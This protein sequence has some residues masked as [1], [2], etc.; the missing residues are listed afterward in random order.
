MP[1][2]QLRITED[3]SHNRTKQDLLQLLDS[4]RLKWIKK[5]DSAE[6]TCG[7]EQLNKFGEACPPHFHL[8]VYFDSPDVKDPLRSAKEFLK[9]KSVEI[10]FRL[11]G[12]KVWSCTLVEEPKDY[13]RWIRYPLKETPCLPFC[14]LPGHDLSHLHVLAKEERKRGVEINILKREKAIDKQSFKDKLFKYLDDHLIGESV[15][16]LMENIVYDKTLPDHQTIWIKVLDYYQS[17]GKAVC[18]QTINGYT[19]LYQLHI[20][21]ITPIQAYH[22][23]KNPP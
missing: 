17:Q 18:F 5:Q 1:Y 9:R 4:F 16:E 3:S 23:R 14:S 6:Y 15:E 13:E 11:K 12:N 2:L 8:N 10:G 19:I 22:M 21:T 7:Y 20:K